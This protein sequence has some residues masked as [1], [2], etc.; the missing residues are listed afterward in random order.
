MMHPAYVR[1]TGGLDAQ[2]AATPINKVGEWYLTICLFFI[3]VEG[4][5][6]EW[7]NTAISTRSM[8]IFQ[9]TP[10]NLW[11]TE[12]YFMTIGL[13]IGAWF[14]FAGRRPWH[15]P[16]QGILIY[17]AMWFVYFGWGLYGAAV[18]HVGWLSDVRSYILPS[19]VAPWVAT[20]A[21][22]SR[23]DVVA[24]RYV[25]MAI[26]AA[27]FNTIISMLFFA[28]GATVDTE[29]GEISSTWQ[30]EY[31]LIF[32]YVLAF[33]RSIC[34]GKRATWTL[35]ILGAG[36]T[37]PLDKPALATFLFANVACLYYAVRLGIK[38]KKIRIGNSA[39]VLMA[40]CLFGLIFG[41]LVLSLGGG[42]GK[43]YLLTRI[44]KYNVRASQRDV[45]GGRFRL[46][47]Y[48]FERFM[49]RPL[50]GV[51]LGDRIVVE[52]KGRLKT[53]PMHNL[54]VQTLSDT[55]LVG[56]TIVSV[57]V[58]T[59]YFRASRAIRD[60]PEEGR[61]WPRLALFV[62]IVSMLFASAYGGVLGARCIAYL[63]WICVGLE[64]GTHSQQVLRQNQ[65]GPE[66]YPIGRIAAVP[67]AR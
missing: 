46:W 40:L 7:L 64:T 2:Y 30:A 57:A 61:F 22:D 51:G 31:V 26:P 10:W 50:V 23:L 1:P 17:L 58:F 54:Y 63:F 33:A 8:I 43:Q 62:F 55:G 65:V 24:G 67:L 49:E 52:S 66:A 12:F 41:S 47:Q 37:A 25:K 5:F 45:A 9:L 20:L 42:A 34:S 3:L 36:I 60:E 35:L 15:A 56:I 16:T 19:L 39:I 4:I 29:R 28:G 18:R 32:A 27:I 59:W 11:P 6:N 44:F 21:K 53:V 14:F 13:L 48:G 38:W